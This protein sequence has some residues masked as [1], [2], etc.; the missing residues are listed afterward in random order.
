MVKKEVVNP[1][2]LARDCWRFNSTLSLKQSIENV[3]Y[4]SGK[5]R[6]LKIGWANQG[7]GGKLANF[8]VNLKSS[9]TFFFAFDFHCDFFKQNFNLRHP[10]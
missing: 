5:L 7:F 1:S 6:N 8:R 10:S 2:G 9:L 3:R 4:Q